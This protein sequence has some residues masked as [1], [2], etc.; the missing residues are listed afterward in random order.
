M[1]LLNLNGLVIHLFVCFS[2]KVLCNCLYNYIVNRPFKLTK[3][4]KK[5][6][7]FQLF[8]DERI[9][10]INEEFGILHFWIL[11]FPFVLFTVG[12]IS[13]LLLL[14]LPRISAIIKENDVKWTV[15]VEILITRISSRSPWF[16]AD[17]FD[18]EY[19]FFAG[20]I[21][22][23]SNSQ[24][25]VCCCFYDG[26]YGQCYLHWLLSCSYLSGSQE[27][28]A[29]WERKGFRRIPKMD[30]KPF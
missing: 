18:V 19:V 14:H 10:K 11:H 13:K 8:I 4:R 15:T 2:Y 9:S 24:F 17:L 22:S 26:F 7:I 27:L 6:T 23:H 25:R 3:N 30:H 20:I 1:F 29:V 21:I 28:M 12:V 5:I 16:D